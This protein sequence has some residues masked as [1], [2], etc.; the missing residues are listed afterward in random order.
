MSWSPVSIPREAKAFCLVD[1][2]ETRSTASG[3][4][5]VEAFRVSAFIE[6]LEE[7]FVL[8]GIDNIF[9]G[10]GPSNDSA[11]LSDGGL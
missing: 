7:P 9:G 10:A 2:F 11:A 3:D 1:K 8:S 4:R 5:E 6:T